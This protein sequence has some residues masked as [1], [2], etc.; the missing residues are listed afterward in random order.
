MVR[1]FQL[2]R[3]P[4]IFFKNGAISSLPDIIKLYGKEVVII[5]GK[6]SFISSGTGL[7]FLHDLEKAA[8][9]YNILSISG[10]PSP[11]NIDEA[12]MKLKNEDIGIVVG[13]GGGSVLDAGKAVSAMM[14]NLYQISLKELGIRN[15]LEQRFHLLLFLLLQVPEVKQQ[16]MRLFQRLELMDS[17]GH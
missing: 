16:K 1:P 5:T 7:R 3:V 12:V 14:Y 2:S 15:I 11:D 10:E 4:K 17:R 8:I 6:K 9:K 13:I